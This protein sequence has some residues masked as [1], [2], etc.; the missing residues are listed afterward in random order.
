MPAW[1]SETWCYAARLSWVPGIQISKENFPRENKHKDLKVMGVRA[2]VIAK[3]L[4]LILNDTGQMQDTQGTAVFQIVQWHQ[5]AQLMAHHTALHVSGLT[6]REQYYLYGY[7]YYQ[8]SMRVRE[9]QSETDLWIFSE[10]SKKYLFLA[11]I[12]T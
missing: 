9:L 4:D 5:A 2:A 1:I 8:S 3:T 12:K 6:D 11:R 7:L 10:A